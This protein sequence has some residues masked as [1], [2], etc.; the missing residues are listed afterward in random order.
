MVMIGRNEVS[1]FQYSSTSANGKKP[2]LTLGTSSVWRQDIYVTDVKVTAVT[3]LNLRLV[4][5]SQTSTTSG[6]VGRQPLV[7][8][9][10][11]NS[12]LNVTFEMPWKVTMQSSTVEPRNWHA[13][14][15]QTDGTITVLGYVEKR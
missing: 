11:A 8:S 1:R 3:A 7:L 14:T 5:G 15:N 2:V 9:C 12:S 10:P 4:A 6:K 13:S